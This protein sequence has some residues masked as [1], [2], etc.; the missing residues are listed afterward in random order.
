VTDI[1]VEPPK[2][3]ELRI[4]I[5]SSAIS[6]SDIKTLKDPDTKFPCILGHEA[7]CIVESVGEGV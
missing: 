6:P 1:E 4:K 3:G 5:L 7:I 2:K